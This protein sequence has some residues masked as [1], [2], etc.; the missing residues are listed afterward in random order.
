MRMRLVERWSLV[1]GERSL[2]VLVVAMGVGGRVR[3]QG[4]GFVTLL[5]LVVV[6]VGGD[7]DVGS[8]DGFVY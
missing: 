2:V 1:E 6:V 3:L 4:H 8:M 7:S 5:L